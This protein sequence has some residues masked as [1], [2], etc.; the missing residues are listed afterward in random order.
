MLDQQS[1][2]RSSQFSLS[3]ADIARRKVIADLTP[4]DVSRILT[5]KDIFTHESDRYTEDF[6]PA[7]T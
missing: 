5:L 6:F 7:R 3:E 1:P 2:P 4:E